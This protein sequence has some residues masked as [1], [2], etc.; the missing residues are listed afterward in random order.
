MSCTVTFELGLSPLFAPHLLVHIVVQTLATAHDLTLQTGRLDHEISH[1]CQGYTDVHNSDSY[2]ICK[3]CTVLQEGDV[4]QLF[5]PFGQITSVSIMKDNN[6]QSQGYG[7]VEFS[8]MPDASK[9]M[10]QWDGQE[11]VGQKLSVKVANMGPASVM[12]QLDLDDDEG[13]FGCL[14]KCM[15]ILCKYH[16]VAQVVY[17]RFSV[18]S[19]LPFVPQARPVCFNGCRL[20]QHITLVVLFFAWCWL[21]LYAPL[22]EAYFAI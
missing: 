14:C 20:L 2:L 13:M 16:N 6:G 5:A 8:S 18:T 10:Q 12:P 15:V 9:A 22:E 19:D 7:Y 17:I 21:A 11:V 4:R 3:V 1:Q